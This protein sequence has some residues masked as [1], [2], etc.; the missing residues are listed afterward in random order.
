MNEFNYSGAVGAS[1]KNNMG[2][3]GDD[4]LFYQSQAIAKGS[5]GG[6]GKFGTPT[7]FNASAFSWISDG[8]DN[9][10]YSRRGGVGGPITW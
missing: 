3:T 9:P 8:L 6:Q 7:G 10:G 2:G 4:M 1:V 5:F